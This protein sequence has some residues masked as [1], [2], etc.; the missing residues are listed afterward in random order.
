MSTQRTCHVAGD[1]NYDKSSI[2]IIIAILRTKKEPD[3][4]GSG[5]MIN[6][7]RCHIEERKRMAR[8]ARRRGREQKQGLTVRLSGDQIRKQIRRMQQ[9]NSKRRRTPGNPGR[10]GGQIQRIGKKQPSRG[11][12]IETRLQWNS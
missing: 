12:N 3:C 2:Y 5:L 10:K 9:Q 11:T 7:E 1:F 8:S 6:R 4:S